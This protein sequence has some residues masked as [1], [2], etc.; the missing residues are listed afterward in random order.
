MQVL[1][2]ADWCETNVVKAA[3]GELKLPQ[4]RQLL[5]RCC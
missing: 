5:Q 2:A 3:V 4:V 1:Q